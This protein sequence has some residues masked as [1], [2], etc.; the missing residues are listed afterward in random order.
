MFNIGIVGNGFVGSAVA[1]GFSPA[2]GFSPVT[3]FDSIVRIYDVDSRRSTHRLCDVVNK[4]DF[5]FV[6]V[7]TPSLPDGS[8][9][10]D[11]VESVVKSISKEKNDISKPIIII[12]STV[13]P[14]TADYLSSKYRNI[15]IVVNP[16]FLT[17]RTAKSDFLCQHNVILGGDMRH[18]DLVRSLY[19]KRFGDSLSVLQTTMKTAE[20][21]KYMINSFFAT[22]ISFMNEMHLIASKIGADWDDVMIGFLRDGRISVSHTS[23]PGHDGK[24]GFGGHCLPKDISAL[25]K[26]A[27]AHGINANVMRGAIETN[28]GI[29]H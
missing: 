24:L 19:Q 18:T 29:R 26:F 8:I 17:E 23:V 27:I 16:E 9:N 25:V 22:K 21:I 2:T 10:I 28:N 4:S 13:I 20:L 12:K 15:D 7:P 5:V 6:C 1:Y 3:G 14:G 11:I